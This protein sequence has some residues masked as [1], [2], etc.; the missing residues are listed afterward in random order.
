MK[1]RKNKK[2]NTND[3]IN[4][5]DTILVLSYGQFYK[6]DPLV[7]EENLGALYYDEYHEF[8][9]EEVE[10]VAEV[11]EKILDLTIVDPKKL[12]TLAYY[13]LDLLE[14]NIEKNIKNG[15]ADNS[16][17]F[18]VDYQRKELGKF[19]EKY[20]KED[21]GI[22]FIVNDDPNNPV[23]LNSDILIY[24]HTYEQVEN[25]ISKENKYLLK[26][27]C[28]LFPVETLCG[29]FDIELRTRDVIA[30]YMNNEIKS[31]SQSKYQC[32][33][34]QDMKYFDFYKA[35]FISLC[36]LLE[37][38]LKNESIY[39]SEILYKIDLD[40][41]DRTKLIEDFEFLNIL[42]QTLLEF[43]TGLN[44]RRDKEV[45]KELEEVIIELKKQLD[46]GIEKLKEQAR[47]TNDWKEKKNDP[48][49]LIKVLFEA[50]LYWFEFDEL[51]DIFQSIKK[52]IWR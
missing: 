27:Y 10:E 2:S 8:G 6:L 21:D 7:T 50:E 28:K 39:G 20:L 33:I 12:L 17:K 36:A 48:L 34:N 41:D 38:F 5:I 47:K 46:I 51:G 45:D 40:N 15:I 1:N 31:R 25:R 49:Y 14:K 19:A 13:R 42:S 18:S 26:W 37:L 22:I 9:D 32:L 44:K 29:F 43:I 23:V 3:I 11:E 24:K 52:R 35:N 16:A 30:I 4:D